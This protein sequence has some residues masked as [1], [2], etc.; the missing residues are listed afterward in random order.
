MFAHGVLRIRSCT[1]HISSQTRI[2]PARSPRG[3]RL[4]TRTQVADYIDDRTS[5]TSEQTNTPR[6]EIYLT[7]KLRNNSSY[8]RALSDLKASLKRS[9]VEYFDLYLMH[10]AIGGPEIRK[11]V[12]RACVDAQKQ[13]LVKSIGV[14][15]SLYKPL[16]RC[17]Q[18]SVE[19]SG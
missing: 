15:L 3:L 18:T 11:E 12:W 7:S 1:N 13:G 10:S 19:G 17:P 8:D 16:R 9:G 6:S 4:W 14:S 2:R 5:L